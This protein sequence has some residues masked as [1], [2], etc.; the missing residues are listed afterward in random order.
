M[1]RIHAEVKEKW[2][3]SFIFSATFGILSMIVMFVFMY[4]L[5]PLL[6]KDDHHSL[7]DNHSD[8]LNFSTQ[9]MTTKD[10]MKMHHSE[11]LILIPGLNLEVL[12]LFILCTPV[13]VNFNINNY[14]IKK[15]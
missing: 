4:A 12:L 9:E 1:K 10:K 14:L 15:I 6:M 8:H 3:N 7:I 11:I 5:P 2:R 13:Q